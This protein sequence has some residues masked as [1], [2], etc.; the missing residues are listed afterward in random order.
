PLVV[1]ALGGIQ[2]RVLRHGE[3]VPGAL[4]VLS[5]FGDHPAR[6]GTFQFLAL[7]R[8]E[9]EI[10][11]VVGTTVTR[12]RRVSVAPR[13][14]QLVDLALEDIAGAGRLTGAARRLGSATHEQV[15]I[16]LEGAAAHVD[17]GTTDSDG[18]F[19]KEAVPPGVYTLVAA[20]T[21]YRSTSVPF[22][23]VAGDV[24]LPTLLLAPTGTDC[25]LGPAGDPAPAA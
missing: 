5:T 17:A 20:A 12:V 19:D 24:A 10:G 15:Q 6:D 23:L 7:A 11:A 2:G 14:T 4:V 9:Y 8:G 13:E 21:G 1:G 18:R 22:V 3:P 25:Q 16:T